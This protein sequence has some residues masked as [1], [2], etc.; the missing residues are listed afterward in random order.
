MALEQA[1]AVP[2]AFRID[3]SAREPLFKTTEG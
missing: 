2:H 1:L 3:Y